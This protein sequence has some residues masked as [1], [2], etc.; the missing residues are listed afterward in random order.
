MDSDSNMKF[1]LVKVQCNLQKEVPKFGNSD[2]EVILLRLEQEE[3]TDLTEFVWF[4]RLS[5]VHSWFFE[6]KGGHCE[7]ACQDVN[8]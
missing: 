1:K 6:E 8:S 5:P 7:H 2:L 4:P 3:R